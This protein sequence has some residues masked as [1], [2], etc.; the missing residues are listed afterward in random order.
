[1]AFIMNIWNQSQ[2]EDSSLE[3]YVRECLKK[4]DVN[5]FPSG[6]HHETTLITVDA[7]MID[8]HGGHTNAQHGGGG[9]GGGHGSKKKHGHG[10]GNSHNNSGGGSGGT[11][12][13]PNT[14]RPHSA[15]KPSTS[16]TNRGRT[17][18]STGSRP[19]S[20]VN[21]DRENSITISLPTAIPTTPTAT[22]TI[23]TTT[24][25]PMMMD[26]I[27]SIQQQLVTLTKA[28][29]NT[30]VTSSLPT[31]YSI[32]ECDDNNTHSMTSGR[33][34]SASTSQLPPLAPSASFANR[35][36]NDSQVVETMNN[37]N[38]VV[39]KLMD[40]VDEM[41]KK[42]LKSHKYLRHRVR[43]NNAMMSSSQ[44]DPNSSIMS[45][46]SP[47]RN[48]LIKKKVNNDIATPS[49]SVD[50]TASYIQDDS[51]VE[52]FT[53][54]NQ[55]FPVPSNDVPNGTVTVPPPSNVARTHSSSRMS[56]GST[57]LQALQQ[58]HRQ[59]KHDDGND[60]DDD[61]DDDEEDK[62]PKPA[63][64]LE[65]SDGESSMSSGRVTV[66]SE[67]EGDAAVAPLMPIERQHSVTSKASMS[68]TPSHMKPTIS[69]PPK[70]L[71][72]NL[73]R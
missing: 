20:A 69:G 59:S 39:L 49:Q 56:V 60:A 71:V 18:S 29:S 38:N 72:S 42:L 30:T 41:E 35:M 8:D 45:T 21:L 73:F 24:S 16:S 12:S 70:S 52:E 3:I 43:S 6:V 57:S 65:N 37:I 64:K 23:P 31:S 14:A 22:T 44:L 10:H 51:E 67:N 32:V 54:I 33:I 68:S 2:S 46:S 5:W 28:I 66:K 58:K 26:K 13:N 55:R 63:S 27:Q 4:G 19:R 34:R 62:M 47:W 1:M 7:H 17:L 11:H 25:D 53:T 50:L 61:G 36:T 15:M 9:H 48:V 40:R